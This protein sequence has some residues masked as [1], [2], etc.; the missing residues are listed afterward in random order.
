MTKPLPRLLA[1]DGKHFC[2]N[3]D[4][5]R[6][7]AAVGAFA[8][9]ISIT[10]CLTTLRQEIEIKRGAYGLGAFAV[11]GIRAGQFIGGTS[12]LFSSLTKSD[13]IYERI[14]R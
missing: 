9:T 5:Q 11:N 14:H 1:P 4:I 3:S 2:Q 13:Y 12:C 6:G 10:R 7:L 8:E